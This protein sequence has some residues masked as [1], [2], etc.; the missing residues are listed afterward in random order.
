MASK[1]ETTLRATLAA[2]DAG[3]PDKAARLLLWLAAL[4]EASDKAPPA[5]ARQLTLPGV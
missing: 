1:I 3:D 2:L 4:L 5:D